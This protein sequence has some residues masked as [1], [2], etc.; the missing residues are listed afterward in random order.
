MLRWSEESSRILMPGQAVLRVAFML[1]QSD[2]Q[3]PSKRCLAISLRRVC[4]CVDWLERTML[5]FV[6]IVLLDFGFG[7]SHVYLNWPYRSRPKQPQQDGFPFS[8]Y[9]RN[10]ITIG[11]AGSQPGHQKTRLDLTC[12]VVSCKLSLEVMLEMKAEFHRM[13]LLSRVKSRC[14]RRQLK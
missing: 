14:S 2:Q 7:T 5:C 11:G 10:M 8:Y 12:H 1:R 13:S 3:S 9:S 4:K 6:S